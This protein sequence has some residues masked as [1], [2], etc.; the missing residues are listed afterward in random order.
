MGMRALNCSTAYKWVGLKRFF[1]KTMC[2]VPCSEE[3]S[4]NNSNTTL[5]CYNF[6][7]RKLSHLPTLRKGPLIDTKPRNAKRE[8][9]RMNEKKSQD[10]QSRVYYV[11]NGKHESLSSALRR[12]VA[13]YST[14]CRRNRSVSLTT[15][16]CWLRWAV[17]KSEH[18]LY[19]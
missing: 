7:R 6:L 8:K 13:W 18:P 10:R 19:S 3:F 4:N 15:M 16:N 12:W 17:E 11:L 5:T 1:L 14:K 9:H 2:Y